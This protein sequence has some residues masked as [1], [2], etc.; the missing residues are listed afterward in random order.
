MLKDHTYT[1]TATIN[2][3]AWYSWE[4]FS[5]VRCVHT[6]CIHRV[7]CACTYSTLHAKDVSHKSPVY[8]A[9][10]TKHIHT[11]TDHFIS[12]NQTFQCSVCFHASSFCVNQSPASALRATKSGSAF[13]HV[14]ETFAFVFWHMQRFPV[15]RVAQIYLHS[16]CQSTL[17]WLYRR[18]PKL[19]S[20]GSLTKQ[21]GV[22]H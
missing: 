1:Q 17:R 16:A 12:L 18:E 11:D 20:G 9:A 19:N 5:R 2:I 22:I 10:H 6:Y 8:I 4:T 15:S 7:Q 13:L 21:N 3:S 14:W